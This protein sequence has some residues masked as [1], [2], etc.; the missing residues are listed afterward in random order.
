M[1]LTD[2][3]FISSFITRFLLI[4]KEIPKEVPADSMERNFKFSLAQHLFGTLLGWT[5]VEEQGHY[6]IGERYDISLYDDEKFPAIIVETKSPDND[7]TKSDEKQLKNY[8]EEIGS[9]RYG[10][11]SN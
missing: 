10:V 11:L 3:S 1:S 5:R 6:V 8:M 7:L 2:E 9:V 4:N